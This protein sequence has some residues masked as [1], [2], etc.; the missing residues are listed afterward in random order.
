MNNYSSDSSKLN[1]TLAAFMLLLG[2]IW[3]FDVTGWNENKPEERAETFKQ[4]LHECEKELAAFNHQLIAELKSKSPTELFGEYSNNNLFEEKGQALFIYEGDTL[5]FWTDNRVPVE[6]QMM[7]VCLDDKVYKLKSGWFLV[8][9][10]QKNGYN[11]Y[12]LQL[13]KNNYSYRNDLIGNHF[14]PRFGLCENDELLL[15]NSEDSFAVMNENGELLFAIAFAEKGVYKPFRSIVFWWVFLSFWT[16]LFLMVHYGSRELFAQPFRVSKSLLILSIALSARI[17][18]MLFQFPEYF[19]NLELFKPTLYAYA[20][21]MGS[22]ADLLIN[23]TLLFI[24]TRNFNRDQKQPLTYNFITGGLFILI[25]TISSLFFHDILID[26]IQ[27]PRLDIDNQNLAELNGYSAIGYVSVWLLFSALLQLFSPLANYPSKMAWMFIASFLMLCSI[28]G[29]GLGT[30]VFQQSGLYLFAGV[31]VCMVFKHR[32]GKIQS[33]AIALLLLSFSIAHEFITFQHRAQQQIAEESALAFVD[34]RDPVAEYLADD[35]SESILNDTT[36]FM[37]LQSKSAANFD[38]DLYIEKTFLSGYWDKFNKQLFVYYADS[39]VKSFSDNVKTDERVMFDSLFNAPSIFMDKNFRYLKESGS[40]WSSLIINIVME[41]KHSQLKG[42]EIFIRLSPKPE[43]QGIGLPALLLDEEITSQNKQRSYSRALY[44]STRL[45]KSEGLYP[46]NPNLNDYYLN[47]LNNDQRHA[48]HVKL[49]NDEITVVVSFEKPNDY[50]VFSYTLFL[51]FLFSA[52]GVMLYALQQMSTGRLNRISL[53][54]RLQLLPAT[55]IILTMIAVGITSIYF[56]RKQ[57][58]EKN[59]LAL[60]EKLQSVTAELESKVNTGIITRDYL[61]LYLR[62]FSSVFQLDLF[63]Y[64]TRGYLIASSQ[65]QITEK[66]LLSEKVHPEAFHRI[67]QQKQ[68]VL[69]RNENIGKQN[70]LSVYGPLYDEN[71]NVLGIINLPYFSRQEVLE[72][73]LSSMLVAMLNIYILMILV[74]LLITIVL[75]NRILKP[76]KLL[77]LKLAGVSLGGKNERIEWQNNDELGQLISEYN[78]MIEQLEISARTIAES[79]RKSAWRDMARQVAHEIKNPLTPMKLQIQLMERAY[80]ENREL[81]DKKYASFTQT[82]I[83]QIETLNH[84]ASEFSGFASMPAPELIQLNV[85]PL[86]Q[87][88]ATLF[89]DEGA[90]TVTVVAASDLQDLVIADKEQLVRVF[91]NL[92]KNAVQS[93]PDQR[94][95]HIEIRLSNTGKDLLIEVKDNGQGIDESLRERIFQPNFTTKSAGMGIGLSMVKTMLRQMNADIW[96]ETET[97]TGTSFFIKLELVQR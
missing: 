86:A 61:S 89:N 60:Y 24:I 28:V 39:L 70:Y 16:C 31:A 58:I 73:E 68:S 84:I 78:R 37:V 36:L 50:F 67:I 65:P 26:L 33:F 69:V 95:G 88:A 8:N 11:F 21:W 4:E 42:S 79:E 12:A 15:E 38:A 19:Y 20:Q 83:E 46:Y 75:G 7:K 3:I 27:N 64:D 97:G 1:K 94:E 72:N 55:M 35:L 57:F 51:F 63:A 93:I 17:L 90:V 23:S 43:L 2:V 14:H 25:L 85:Q 59:E 91:N 34:F 56:I 41:D 77:Q 76:L 29:F 40:D 32:L 81:F 49:L 44:H 82:L 9:H 87:Q 47:L 22:P 48:H 10:Q 45:V 80:R 92:L 54:T 53:N 13:I 71:K 5:R 52:M 74:S 18:L 66:G 6:N 30:E 96:F 62:K